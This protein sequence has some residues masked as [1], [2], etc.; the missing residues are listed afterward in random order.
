MKLTL[1]HTYLLLVA[2]F[3]S[4]A[5]IVS[6]P[7]EPTRTPTPLTITAEEL[8]QAL[9]EREA[10]DQA[11]R[12]Q[13][14]E[15]WRD[16]AVGAELMRVDAENTAWLKQVVVTFGW[17]SQS[18]VGSRAADAAWLL[19]QHADHDVAF[20]KEAL[21]LMTPLVTQNEVT[22]KNYAYLYDRVATNE[23]RPQRYGT[24]GQCTGAHTWEPN[25]LEDPTQVDALRRS[26]DLP[27]LDDYKKQFYR[28]CP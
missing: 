22:K 26:M 27:P 14:A 28:I 21:A 25:Q 13:L 24:Q 15:N 2:L 23:G 9:L 10:V 12:A 20:Q 6:L 5:C 16:P 19:V 4:A 17:P 11:V 1:T 18:L 8:R 3:L 7:T